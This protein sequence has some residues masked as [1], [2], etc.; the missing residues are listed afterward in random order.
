MMQPVEAIM[1][2]VAYLSKWATDTALA[3]VASPDSFAVLKAEAIAK[4]HKLAVQMLCPKGTDAS[5]IST[6]DLQGYAAQAQAAGRNPRVVWVHPTYAPLQ[7]PGQGL[8]NPLQSAYLSLVARGV[9]AKVPDAQVAKILA[10]MFTDQDRRPA[11]T[12]PKAQ[13]F[14]AVYLAEKAGKIVTAPRAG[15][16]IVALKADA[17]AQRAERPKGIRAGTVDPM[18]QF[19]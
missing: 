13:Y 1:K 16:Y 4:V 15:G 10:E 7:Q 18:E 3:Y 14:A 11:V 19:V 9:V 2:G 17:D 5:K 6:T 12:E 8:R